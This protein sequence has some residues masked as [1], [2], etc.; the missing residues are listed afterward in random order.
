MIA[1]QTIADIRTAVDA[2][3]LAAEYLP[4]EKCGANWQTKCPWHNGNNPSSLRI[5][6]NGSHCFTCG[7]SYSP[8]D[9]V[10]LFEECSF[11]EAV[12]MLAERTGISLDGKRISK[13]QSN[14]A[15][16]EA[17]Y[18]RWW[19]ARRDAALVDG[20]HDAMDDEEWAGTLSRIK[21]HA[22]GLTHQLRFTMFLEQRSA[23]DRREYR[24]WQANRE[25]WR[26]RL[27]AY[28][29]SGAFPL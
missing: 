9:W 28:C 15:R 29:H 22:D 16:E 8:I 11:P 14:L 5:Y 13:A 20:I 6:K 21:Q 12:R 25:W 18:C 27:R 26:D 1:P 2:A 17:E 24:E 10:M 7:R 23:E 3:V 19:W 4:I